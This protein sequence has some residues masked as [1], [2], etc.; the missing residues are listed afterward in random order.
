M[1]EALRALRVA[2]VDLRQRVEQE[3]LHHYLWLPGQHAFLS[4]DSRFKLARWGNQWGGKTTA[5][6]AD[7]CYA[8]QGWHPLRR[9]RHRPP[10]EAWVIC[11]TWQQ[12]IAI[13]QKLWELVPKAWI[14]ENTLFDVGRGL[15]GKNP[16]LRFRN[17]SIIRIKTTQ[18]GGLNLSSA[19][20]HVALFDEPPR[21]Q[22]IYSEV[23]KRVLKTRGDVMLTLTPIN[24]PTDWLRERVEQGKVNDHHFRLEPENLVPVGWHRPVRLHDGTVCDTDWIAE[25][26]EETLPHEVPVTVHGEWE[27]RA[28]GNVF[29][30]FRAS[31]VGAHVHER[32][33][34]G[35]F[36]VQL[37]ID[38]GSGADFSSVAVLS[39]IVPPEDP[40]GYPAVWILDAYE[41]QGETTSDQDAAAIVAMLRHWNLKW[42]QVDRVFGDKPYTKNRL[43]TK[44]NTQLHKAIARH[45]R[46]PAG[47]LRPQIR[48]VKRGKGHGAG[49]I[50]VGCQFLH[51]CMLRPGHFNVHPRADAVTRALDRWDYRDNAWKHAIDALRYSVDNWIFS[52]RRETIPSVYVY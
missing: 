37:G 9:L 24:A 22:R 31:G 33:P 25:V 28:I 21:T 51:R 6:L 47:R 3:Q 39:A 36:K 5:G 50:H 43:V 4:D 17:G 32:L 13:Q 29:R 34:R 35:E 19:T 2:S 7:V 40:H 42:S 44:S 27:M 12:S 8:C 45:L 11:A 49:S 10:I 41:S 48:Q 16:V 38:H 23:Q 18:Q 15:I 46:T 52:D 20:I 26:I 1:I 14:D 30:R